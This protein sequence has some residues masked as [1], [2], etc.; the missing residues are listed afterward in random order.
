MEQFCT[1]VGIAQEFL[2]PITPQQNGIVEQKNRV[3]QEMARAMMHNKDVAKYLWGEVVN[4][5]CHTVNKVYFRPKQRKLL[6]NC[7]K[8]ES[9]M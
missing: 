6:M 7:G 9:Q 2:A 4:I 3:I 5:A 1:E 8:G